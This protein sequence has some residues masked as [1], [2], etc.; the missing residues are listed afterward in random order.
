M[1][2]ATQPARERVAFVEN[3]G[4]DFG[5]VKELLEICAQHNHWANRG[6]LYEKLTRT[7]A[8]HVGIGED[9]AFV[10][11]A[12]GGIALEVMARQHDAMAGAPLRWV[13][14]AFSFRNLGRGYFASMQFVDCDG[15]GLL[16]LARLEALD[17]SSYDGIVLTNPFG[18]YGDFSEYVQFAQERGKALLVDNASGLR[19]FVPMLPWQAFSLHQT[20]PYGLG[21]GG[22]ALVPRRFAEEVYER[23]SYGEV[24]SRSPHWVQNGKISDVACA[25]LI[26]RLE[27]SAEWLRLYFEQCERVTH[28]AHRAGLQ[29]LAEP[30]GDLPMTSLPVVSE[31]EVTQPAVMAARHMT[32]GKYYIPLAPLPEVTS[33]FRRLVNIPCHPGMAALT[34]QEIYDDL[35]LVAPAARYRRRLTLSFE[36]MNAG[37]ALPGG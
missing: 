37:T 18:L 10:P 28:I 2:P 22:L 16:D 20:K 7:L 29:A 19:R 1:A 21:E 35:V 32:M 34:D 14:S 6:P 11:V 33:L 26:A 3:K 17:P 13:G 24:A 23:V 15:R 9:L 27:A 8:A 31:R 5:R 12:N 4:I 25:F 30:P 36:G